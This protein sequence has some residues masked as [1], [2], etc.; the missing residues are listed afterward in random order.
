[1]IPTQQIAVTFFGDYAAREKREEALAADELAG[2][3]R[4]MIAPEKQRLP[5]LKLA[6]FG[7]QRSDKNSLRHDAN[8]IAITGGRLRRRDRRLRRGSRDRRKGGPRLYSLHFTEQR[9]GKAALARTVPNKRGIAAIAPDAPCRAV[10]R[11]LWRHLRGRK[12]HPLAELLLWRGR[13]Q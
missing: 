5:W 8:V 4:T 9:A 11:P 12:L 1:M 13:Q 6:R 7:F 2:R 10:E 3:I